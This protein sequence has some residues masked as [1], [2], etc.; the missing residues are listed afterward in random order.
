MDC[1]LIIQVE[2]TLTIDRPMLVLV[3]ALVPRPDEIVIAKMTDQAKA[4][5]VMVDP[6]VSGSS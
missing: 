3:Q 4:R 6:S 1:P 2:D 5:V